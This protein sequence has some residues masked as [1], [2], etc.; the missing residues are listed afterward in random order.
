MHTH[1]RGHA[2]SPA[3]SCALTSKVMRAHQQDHARSPARSCALTSKIMRAQRQGHAHS[4][5][6]SCEGRASSRGCRAPFSAAPARASKEPE[7]SDHRAE[8]RSSS[9]GRSLAAAY[10]RTRMRMQGV[11]HVESLRKGAERWA[12]P[13][14]RVTMREWVCVHA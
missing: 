3:R 14:L 11:A 10:A 1:L 13:V 4:P 12:V 9:C 2:R 5:A 8:A 7:G 6:R